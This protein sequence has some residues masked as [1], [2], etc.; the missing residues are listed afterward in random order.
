MNKWIIYFAFLFINLA[1]FIYFLWSPK[2]HYGGDIIEYYGVT[3]S[4]INH[5]S[6]DLTKEDQNNLSDKLGAGYFQNPEYY[7]QG[8][9]G[10]RYPV[11]FVAYSLLNIPT[12]LFLEL[13]GQNPIKTF[14]ITNLIILALISFITTKYFLKSIFQKVIF[15][16]FVYLSPIIYHLVWPGPEVFI[17]SLL[18]LSIFLFFNKKYI[19]AIVFSAAAS[20]QSQPLIFIPLG[21][22]CFYLYQEYKNGLLLKKISS[23]F[24]LFFIFIP[25]I[26]YFFI[27]GQFSAWSKLSGVGF[28]NFSLQKLFE[29]YFDLNIGLFFY[30]PVVFIIGIYQLIKRFRKDMRYLLILLQIIL[31][32]IFYLT[33]TNW[34]N[35]SSGFGPTR[36]SIFLIPF[37]I[38][39]SLEFFRKSSIHHKILVLFLASQLFILSFN[40]F[41]MPDL[42]NSKKHTPY[43]TFF[44]NNFPNLYNPTPEIFI[45]RT[46]SKEGGQWETSIYKYQGQC[47]KAYVLTTDLNKA[48][49]ECGSLPSIK[50]NEYVNY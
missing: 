45:E 50:K 17:S 46:S 32:S 49:E 25:N 21:F 3:E 2:L 14:R 29:L 43:A 48:V 30:L 33:N 9:N 5:Q 38:F 34:N 40:G 18:L 4:I 6:L 10:Y 35:G 19:T 26:Y 12:R 47:K 7:I 13:F 28:N 36:Y 37:L 31:V 42:D 1:I 39:F 22:L 20:W 15:V 41:L 23:A 24:L 44:L 16:I 8:L 11:H 27:F